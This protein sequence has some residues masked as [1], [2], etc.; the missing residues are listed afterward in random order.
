MSPHSGFRVDIPPEAFVTLLALAGDVSLP[1]EFTPAPSAQSGDCGR[2]RAQGLLHLVRLG[3]VLHEADGGTVRLHPAMVSIL[4]AQVA[5]DVGVQ[6]RGWSGE[7]DLLA[8]VA[9]AQ[10]RGSALVRLCSP[11]RHDSPVQL[12]A[13]AGSDVVTEV[14][15]YVRVVGQGVPRGSGRLPALVELDGAVPVPGSAGLLGGA[16]AGFH[17]LVTASTAPSSAWCE[18]WLADATG[19]WRLRLLDAGSCGARHARP[20]VLRLE[21]VDEYD[22]T[23]TLAFALAGLLGPVRGV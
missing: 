9:V 1:E 19:W 23:R 6:V 22:L 18:E 17:L 4:R 10:L 7:V 5:P 15:R 2:G 3:L 8:S 13:F 11:G 14:V 21:P 16:R 12:S 20:S